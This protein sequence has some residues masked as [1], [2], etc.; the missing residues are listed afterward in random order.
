MVIPTLRCKKCV[1]Q[2]SSV[3]KMAKKGDRE[4]NGG[5][6]GRWGGGSMGLMRIQDV[7]MSLVGVA[8]ILD[9]GYVLVGAW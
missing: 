8:L 9:G 2:A 1:I 5:L 3:F 4:R 7:G 6:A